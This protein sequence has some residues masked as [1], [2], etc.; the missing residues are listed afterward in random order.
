MFNLSAWSEQRPRR[1]EAQRH[2]YAKQLSAHLPQKP[3][4]SVSDQDLDAM[5]AAFIARFDED[6][7]RTESLMWV[8]AIGYRMAIRDMAKNGRG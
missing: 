3:E 4:T 6:L 8:A 5:R 7:P 1:D 2:E